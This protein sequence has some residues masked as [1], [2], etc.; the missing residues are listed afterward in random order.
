MLAEA[1]IA[2]GNAYGYENS[3]SVGVI[4]ELHRTVQVSDDQVYYDLIQ[5]DAAINPGNSGGPLLNINGEM[6]GL[7]VA[8]RV[9]AQ[10]IAFAI[11][12]NQVMDVV[13]N[14]IAER[15][16]SKTVHGV[17]GHTD[18][19]GNQLR[20]IVDEVIENSPANKAGL[21]PG[22]V[23]LKVDS[24]DVQNRFDFERSFL[25]RD[26]GQELSLSL[27]RGTEPMQ[28]SLVM[29]TLAPSTRVGDPAWNVLGVKLASIATQD[30]RQV[31]SRYN[32]GMRVVDVRQD[33]PADKRG[34]RSGDVL[35]GIHIWET[36]SFKDLR[37]I[38]TRPEVVDAD[39]GVSFFI[40]RGRE[41]FFGNI[42]LSSNVEPVAGARR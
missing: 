23:V 19:T 3:V 37:Y 29:K 26:A 30:L 40:L 1:V 21:V 35:V 8:V 18:R 9:G 14:L 12:I 5:T 16:G 6:I 41:E 33:S 17:V 15:T 34:I 11:P 27:Q 10:G 20:F 42:Q 2:I 32:G 13:S 31:T 39:Q 4:S 7:N 38:L 36:T 24:I 28:A 25:D 22:D